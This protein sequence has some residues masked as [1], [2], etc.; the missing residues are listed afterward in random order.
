[1]KRVIACSSLLAVVLA[2]VAVVRA[3][4]TTKERAIF[5][6][7]GMMGGMINR[8]MGG[9]DGIV[10]TVAVKGNRMARKGEKTGQIIDLGEEK[11]YTLDIGKKEYTVMTF[12]EFRQMMEEAKKRAADQQAKMS[13]QDKQTAQDAAKQLEF[14]VDVKKTGQSKSIAGYT[15]EET[16]LTITMHEKGKKVE[17]SGGMVVT[18]SLWLAPKIAALDEMR[19]FMVK[20]AKAMNFGAMVD[21][22]AAGPVAALLPGF[23]QMSEKLAAEAHKLQGSTVA[24]TMVFETVKSPEAMKQQPSGGGGGIGGALAGRFMNRGASQQRTKGLTMTNET[25]SVATSASE[26]DLA[27]PAGFKEKKK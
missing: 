5:K 24:S 12:A 16:V 11:V 6:M 23:G 27:I 2:G 25:L 14:D 17:E 3:D 18:N 21:A 15:A 4:V 26:A 1:M 20:Y 13:P 10:S 9:D 7:E 8:A 22:Q 19:D